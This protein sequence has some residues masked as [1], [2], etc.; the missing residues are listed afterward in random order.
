MVNT[1]SFSQIVA[2]LKRC[3]WIRVMFL[4]CR[5]EINR[6]TWRPTIDL[7][8]FW[9]FMLDIPTK[10]GRLRMKGKITHQG[11]VGLK[12]VKTIHFS[13]FRFLQSYQLV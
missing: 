2:C 10:V 6:G 1:V 13:T 11:T 12:F 4:H 8:D 5:Q 3:I 9:L 7:F